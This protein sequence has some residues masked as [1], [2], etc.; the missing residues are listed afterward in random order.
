MIRIEISIH[1][2]AQG[3]TFTVSSESGSPL[4]QSTPPRRGRRA[5]W[6]R[7]T[8]ATYFNPRPR[9]GGDRYTASLSTRTCH[10]NPRPRA[11][12]DCKLFLC[13]R[14]GAKFQSTPPRRGR[15]CLTCW[16]RWRQW[17]FNPRPCAGGDRLHLLQRKSP[18]KHF[19]PRP[20]AGGDSKTSLHSHVHLIIFTQITPFPCI[21][22]FGIIQIHAKTSFSIG[23][24]TAV[25]S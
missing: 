6:A 3:A 4:F 5:I 23:A 22:P 25:F 15:R 14:N 7:R 19:N 10:F 1:A 11:G 21:F 20:C 16:R 2:P 9:A 17:N 13:L 8:S 12:G 24:N 18:Q